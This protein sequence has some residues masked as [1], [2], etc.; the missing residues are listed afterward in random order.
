MTTILRRTLANIIGLVSLAAIA[1]GIVLQGTTPYGYALVDGGGRLTD[2]GCFALF[3]GIMAALAALLP[4]ARW[5][6]ETG[7]WQG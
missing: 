2:L 5:V 3:L 6:D 1:G 7:R 4:F